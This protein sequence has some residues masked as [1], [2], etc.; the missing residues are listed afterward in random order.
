MLALL[1]SLFC[2]CALVALG[3][4][5]AAALPAVGILL[6]WGLGVLALPRPRWG[7]PALFVAG[8]TLRLVLVAAPVSLSDDLF[9]YL[10][11]GRVVWEGGNPYLHAPAHPQ[12]AAFAADPIL[13]RVN[14]PE[15][16][17]IYPPL[18][19][20]LFA[21]LGS[22]HY[23]PL[24]IK[25]F[26]GLCDALTA[27]LLGRVLLGRKRSLNGAWLYALMPLGAVES[28]GSGHL[29]AVSV[30]CLVA[31]I[32]AWD[33]QLSGIGWAGLGALFKLMP[34]A[35]L[36]SLWLRSPWLFGL[37]TFVGLLSLLPFLDAGP[38]LLRGFN[39]YV[40]HW[41]FNASGFALL[42]AIFGDFGRTVGLVMGAALSLWA[43]LRFRDPARVAL[44]VG[45][46]FVLLSPTV[47]PWYILWAWVPALLCGVRAWTLLAALV[48]VAYVVL[49]TL[50]PATG[51]WTEAT[52]PRWLQYLPFLLALGVEALTHLRDPGPWAPDPLETRS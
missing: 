16:S 33:R 14:H 48:P 18:A 34:G 30:L 43:I 20:L 5:R 35:V 41:S 26:M 40:A 32:L 17:S 46:A 27:L 12:W 51:Q 29:E 4:L 8:L 50:D 2:A 13:Q 15:I 7:L 47:H 38:A 11:E 36:P 24:S 49:A 25:L 19:L 6:V 10:W 37:L 39:T 28:A 21:A 52:W 9:R 1:L 23:G 44:W 42:H 45:G 3:D 31:A 22:L